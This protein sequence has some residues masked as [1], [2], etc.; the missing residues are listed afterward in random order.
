[1]YVVVTALYIITIFND[2]Q[3]K[4]I[5]VQNGWSE[6]REILSMLA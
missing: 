4:K 6:I 5:I 2:F 1:M 3:L